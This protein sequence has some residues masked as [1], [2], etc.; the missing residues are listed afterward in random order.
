MRR[1]NADEMADRFRLWHSYTGRSICCINISQDLSDETES[2]PNKHRVAWIF[3]FSHPTTAW[4]ADTY[5]AAAI[6][7]RAKTPEPRLEIRL[8]ALI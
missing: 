8:A 3:D 4:E 5:P 7:H 1:A 6:D 2:Q